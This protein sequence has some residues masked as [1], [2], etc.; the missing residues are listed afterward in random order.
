MIPTILNLEK[1]VFLFHVTGC[2][3]CSALTVTSEETSGDTSEFEFEEGSWGTWLSITSVK[4]FTSDRFSSAVVLATQ[5]EQLQQTQIG[6]LDKSKIKILFNK[7]L[8]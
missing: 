6:S 2:F 1:N 4:W 7:K 5:W 3:I 8:N